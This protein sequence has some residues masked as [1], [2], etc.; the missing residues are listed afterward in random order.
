MGKFWARISNSVFKWLPWGIKA[1]AFTRVSHMKYFSLLLASRL[2]AWLDWALP[3]TLPEQALLTCSWKNLAFE[4]HH[5]WMHSWW[6]EAGNSSVRFSQ[7]TPVPPGAYNHDFI[8]LSPP[9]VQHLPTPAMIKAS[10]W[11]QLC[12]PAKH[13]GAGQPRS[14]LGMQPG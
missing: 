5:Y 8:I 1:F 6:Q 2:G 14:C 9:S 4:A 3:A 11:S 13:K 10:V 12:N 7:V